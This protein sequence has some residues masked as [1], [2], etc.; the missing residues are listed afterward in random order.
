MAQE[1]AP[2]PSSRIKRVGRVLRR[3]VAQWRAILLTMALIAATGF[4][5]GYFH[6]V[7]RPDMQTD[8]AARHQAIKAASDGAV[9]LLSYSPETLTQDFNNAKSRVSENYLPYYQQFAEKV[10]G[11]VGHARPGHHKSHGDQ[12]RR[13]GNAPEFSS[14]PCIRQD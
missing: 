5:A 14:R 13:M 8:D 2:R 9:A 3:G 4:A 7:Y 6:S 10:V 1:S 12:S 11:D